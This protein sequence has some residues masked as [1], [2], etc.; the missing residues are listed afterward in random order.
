LPFCGNARFPDF[1]AVKKPLSEGSGFFV[2]MELALCA[3]VAPA[4]QAR[5]GVFRYLIRYL[6]AVGTEGEGAA[7]NFIMMKYAS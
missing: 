3:V 5:A 7:M 4:P 1:I 2:C 6:L